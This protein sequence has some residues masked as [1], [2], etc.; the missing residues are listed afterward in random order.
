MDPGPSVRDAYHEARIVYRKF[1]STLKN[2]NNF[3]YISVNNNAMETIQASHNESR[4]YCYPQTISR[5]YLS[6]NVANN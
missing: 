3:S 4:K 1:G 2:L 5:R 6:I